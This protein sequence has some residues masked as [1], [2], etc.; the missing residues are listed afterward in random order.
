MTQQLQTL[1][2]WRGSVKTADAVREEI[3]RRYGEAEAENYNPEKN[4]FT[5]Q[6]WK[7]LGYRV[8]KGEKAIRSITY[9][10]AKDKPEKEKNTDGEEQEIRKYPKTV[11]LFYI[12]Q[13][14]K[15]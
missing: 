2:H 6:T 14:E 3:A 12:L 1:A 15:R 10:E 4:C 5:F 13:V 7:A 8:K 11:Y 9:V